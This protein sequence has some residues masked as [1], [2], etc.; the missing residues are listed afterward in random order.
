MLPRHALWLHDLHVPVAN[1]AYAIM[2][3]GVIGCKYHDY[4]MLLTGINIMQLSLLHLKTVS[5]DFT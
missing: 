3:A 2:H 4:G 1:D 5:K